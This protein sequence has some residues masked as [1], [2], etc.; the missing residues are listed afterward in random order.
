MQGP[1]V[2]Y[3]PRVHKA[4]EIYYNIARKALWKR[5][6]EPWIECCPGDV[7]LHGAGMRH[8]MRTLDEPLVG[9]AV[10]ISDTTSPVAIVR[11]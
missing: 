1:D 7:I 10:R 8:A 3:P 11:T 9:M 6:D 4:I 5:G 2:T